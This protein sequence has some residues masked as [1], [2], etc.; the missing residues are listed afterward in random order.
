M[1]KAS[2]CICGEPFGPES[3]PVSMIGEEWAHVV[4]PA[5]LMCCVCG[6]PPTSDNPLMRARIKEFAHASC[7]KKDREGHQGGR[8]LEGLEAPQEQDPGVREGA[9]SVSGVR[10]RAGKGRS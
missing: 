2:C 1:T 5:Q 9:G 4:C 3:G 8:W 10:R 7:W 6:Q